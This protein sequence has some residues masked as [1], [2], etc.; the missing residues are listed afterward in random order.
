MNIVVLTGA[1]VSAE[2]G[3][4]TFRANDGLWENHRVEDVATPEAFERD[5]ELVYRFYNERRRGLLSATVKPNDAHIALAEF[6]KNSEHNVT[7][8]TQNIDN[9]HERGGS[10]NVIHMHG[11]LLKARCVVTGKS[12]EI[13]TDFDATDK[14]QCCEPGNEIRPHIVWFGEV[15]FAMNGIENKLAD[16]DMFIS[17]G[18]SG[19]VYPAAGFVAFAK[20]VGAKTVE[21]NLEPSVTNSQF[22]EHVYGPAT[23]VLPKFLATL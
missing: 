22:D 16:C 4:K 5:P 1:G 23:E 15:P 11:E 6:A 13:T 7:I 3:I 9:L 19:N 10:E 17:L 18:T 21:V 2:S 20:S 8:V 14:C 12:F